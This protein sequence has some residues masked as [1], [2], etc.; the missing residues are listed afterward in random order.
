M[1]NEKIKQILLDIKESSLDFSVTLTGKAC[2]T[3]NGLYKPETREIL[4][5]NKNFKSE[6]MLIYTA[7]HE[8]TH[9][10]IN[11]QQLEETGG[12]YVPKFTRVHNQQFWAKFHDLLEIA[13]QK[14]YY[15]LS[16]KDSPE[17]AELTE[18]IKKEYLET[19]GRLMQEFGKLLAKAHELCEKEGIRYEDYLDRILCMPRTSAKD[20]TKVGL[21]QVNHA[22]GFDKMKM[23]SSIKKPEDRQTAEQQLLSGKSPNTVREMMKKKS[24]ESSPKE[25]L[26]KERDRLNKTIAQLTQRL[27]F[28]EESLAQL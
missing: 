10:L 4:L 20:I 1:D 6:N 13:E 26:E 2:K 19:N 21:T 8:Y 25:K 7:V 23:L 28:V 22:L 18:K 5:H 16:I 9:H 15:V 14:G 24:K 17:L 27:E 11:E 3:V 12:K